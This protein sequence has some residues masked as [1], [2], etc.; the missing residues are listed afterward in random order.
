MLVGTPIVGIEAR[1]VGDRPGLA[2]R[3][4]KMTLVLEF[5]DGS[6]G[7]IHYFANGS[8]RYSKERIEAFSD[9]RVLA[10][11]N[12]RSLVGY[13]WPGFTRCRMWRQDKG[14]TAEMA[15]FVDRLQAGGPG[16]IPWPE[17]EEITLATLAAVERAREPPR[18]IF[19]VS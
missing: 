6:L 13:G 18:P 10:M 2:I 15:A 1:M 4:D 9:G 8:K 5:A 14:H 19:C 11:D 17:L 16:L 12:F 7:T 3:E